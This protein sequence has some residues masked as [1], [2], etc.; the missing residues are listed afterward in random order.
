MCY[1]IFII[2]CYYTLT[3]NSSHLWSV[4]GLTGKMGEKEGSISS[5]LT[6]YQIEI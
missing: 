5:L 4:L 3:Y 6:M 2:F 1:Y